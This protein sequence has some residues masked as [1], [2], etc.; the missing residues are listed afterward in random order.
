M[1]IE[2]KLADIE[3]EK[4]LK[5]RLGQP[6]EKSSSSASLGPFSSSPA[7]DSSSSLNPPAQPAPL[8]RTSATLPAAED[9]NNLSDPHANL[10][11]H[12]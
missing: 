9:Q 8:D 1:R 4:N 3:E 12:T 2:E 6:S 5:K 7:V 10:G 11:W